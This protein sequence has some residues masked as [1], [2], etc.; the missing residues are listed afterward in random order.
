MKTRS[1]GDGA[2]V[3]YTGRHT[4]KQAG[5]QTPR[6]T[7]KQTDTHNGLFSSEFTVSPSH[8]VRFSIP[9]TMHPALHNSNTPPSTQT[10]A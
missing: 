10:Q 8:A 1:V 5:M 2:R 9:L 3:E 6:P 7:D 4:G